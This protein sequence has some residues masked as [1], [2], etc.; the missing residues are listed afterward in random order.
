M[1]ALL[2]SRLFGWLLLG[3]LA[4]GVWL[5]GMW[6]LPFLV[7]WHLFPAPVFWVE[8]IATGAATGMLVWFFAV[9]ILRVI[10]QAGH[11]SSTP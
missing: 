9:I 6:Q 2:N 3:M 5:S 1:D 4:I 8:I 10:K 11:R 7:S